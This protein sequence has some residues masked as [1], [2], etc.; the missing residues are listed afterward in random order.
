MKVLALSYSAFVYSLQCNC[1]CPRGPATKCSG[2]LV[3]AL[4]RDPVTSPIWSKF[5]SQIKLLL[6]SIERD[7]FLEF[8]GGA[9]QVKKLN[10][11]S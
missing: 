1:Y 9:D 10:K 5:L 4:D 2:N 7:E 11:T 8:G 3:F 6:K